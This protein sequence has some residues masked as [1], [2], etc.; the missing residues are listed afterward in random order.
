MRASRFFQKLYFECPLTDD[1]L[2]YAA[3]KFA[4]SPCDYQIFV[5]DSNADALALVCELERL[6]HRTH[7]VRHDIDCK[8]VIVEIHN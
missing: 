6:V 8:A 7:K 1:S 3:E 4:A 5:M 2:R